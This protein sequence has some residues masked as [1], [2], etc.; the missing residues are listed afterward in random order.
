MPSCLI[1]KFAT[2]SNIHVQSV[3]YMDFSINLLK[4]Q[5]DGPQIICIKIGN[6]I[7]CLRI[8]FSVCTLLST[9]ITS[10]ICNCNTNLISSPPPWYWYKLKKI[11]PRADLFIEECRAKL[12]YWK[13]FLL[14]TTVHS[15][16]AKELEYISKI[17]LLQKFK[18]Y[19]DQLWDRLPEHI[20]A[21]SATSSCL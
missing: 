5:F 20:K 21:D 12:Q 15:L 7:Q 11:A 19:I 3:C 9:L 2:I 13:C 16:T 1:N 14:W 8:F 6:I 17:I 10:I 18:N 4:P